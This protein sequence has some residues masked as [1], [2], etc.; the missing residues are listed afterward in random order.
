[1]IGSDQMMQWQSPEHMTHSYV[2]AA[3]PAI[4]CVIAN[5]QRNRKRGVP[6][7]WS[8]HQERQRAEA[9]AD[10]GGFKA[11]AQRQCQG[12]GAP[13]VLAVRHV[14]LPVTLPADARLGVIAPPARNLVAACNQIVLQ[15]LS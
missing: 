11:H 5:L 12:Q 2:F 1:M 10:A 13:A 9:Q 8:G 7:A 4:K 14:M 6:G 3:P 15:Y